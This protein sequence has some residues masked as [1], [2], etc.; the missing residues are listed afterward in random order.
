MIE[1]WNE[2][3]YKPVFNGLIWIYNNW[4]DG[5]LGWAIIYLTIL[6]RFA[7]LPFTVIDARARA[8]NQGLV[9]ELRSIQKS[10]QNDPVMMK[11]EAR[12]VLR[13]RKV[14]PWA[15]AVVLGI[16]ALVLVL[17]Y[18]VFAQG[19]TGEKVAKILYPSVDFPGVINPI[20]YGFDLAA[21]QDWIAAGIVMVWLMIEIYWSFRKRD[22]DLNRSDLAYF[23]LFPI[24]VFVV[25]W[26]LPMVKA[27]FIL[28]SL[29]FSAIVGRFLRAFIRPKKAAT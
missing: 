13:Q 25:L 17:L 14:K 9:D 8:K 26:W 12:K 18:Q 5:N 11:E 7:L 28:T 23:L 29:V 22:G 16:Q 4:T 2:F 15:K 1:F 21:T 10:Y 6:L 20:F 19:V 24:A 27:L 3:L